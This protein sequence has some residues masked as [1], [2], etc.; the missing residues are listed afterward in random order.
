MMNK[1]STLS[2]VLGSTFVAAVTMAPVANAA[3]SPFAMQTLDKGYMTADADATTVAAP[4]MT[5]TTEAKCSAAKKTTEAKCSAAKKAAEAKCS[6]AKKAAEAK[7][8][9]AKKAAE[10]KCS[11]AKKA[12]Q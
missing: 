2:L 11:A 9:A 6:A 8:S 12:A 4:D 7:C 1:K 5:K 10:A 3:Q